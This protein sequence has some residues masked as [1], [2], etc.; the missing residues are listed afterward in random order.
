MPRCLRWS[1]C[2]T[3]PSEAPKLPGSTDAPNFN[4]PTHSAKP[5]RNHVS[6]VIARSL[7]DRGNYPPVFAPP[8]LADCESI[9]SSRRPLPRIMCQGQVLDGM[10]RSHAPCLTSKASAQEGYP[11]Y[12]D[13]LAGLHSITHCGVLFC[14]STRSRD[15][16]RTKAAL[17]A[18]A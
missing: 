1:T 5:A 7:Q 10:A 8:H 3:L 18:V 4:A 9:V 6:R 2:A 12:I 13:H 16:Y 15:I 11:L 14:F 17:R